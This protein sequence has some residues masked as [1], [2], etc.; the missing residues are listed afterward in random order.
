MCSFALQ[1]FDMFKACGAR[2]L[3]LLKRHSFVYTF[4]TFQV[5]FH[6]CLDSLLMC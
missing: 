4:R 6:R 2:D 3:T 1:A 5:S